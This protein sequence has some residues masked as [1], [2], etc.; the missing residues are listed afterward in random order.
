[1]QCNKPV[2]LEFYGE[3]T[4]L[5]VPCGKCRA[6]R[7][8]HSREW[9]VRILHESHYYANSTFITLTYNDSK[10]P[11][12][13]SVSIRE[14]QLF[15]KK[16]RKKTDIKIKYFGCGEYGETYGRPHY[17][18]IIFGLK[19]DNPEHQKWINEAWGQGFTY[20][21]SVTYDSARYVADYIQKAFLGEGQKEYYKGKNPPFKLVSQGIGERFCLEYQDYFKD[22]L[23]LTVNG[24]K[25]GLPKFYR[26][27]LDIPTEVL[28]E[29]SKENK[30]KVEEHY[31]N[32]YHLP[33]KIWEMSQKSRSQSEKNL[34]AFKHMHKRKQ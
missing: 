3:K 1:M 22:N 21:G 30:L 32:K 7:I 25:M 9:A 4:D 29:K 28:Y 18:G 23:G 19:Y 11:E 31:E 6:C 14:W 5:M 15:I 12:N 33:D 20:Y 34:M 26:K 10:L 2:R 24:K 16:L 27:K 8:A 13:E 17:H